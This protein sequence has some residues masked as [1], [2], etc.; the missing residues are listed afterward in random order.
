MQGV[1]RPPPSR[2]HCDAHAHAAPAREPQPHGVEM[3]PAQ[4]AAVSLL[5]SVGRWPPPAGEPRG[6]SPVSEPELETPRQRQLPAGQDCSSPSGL[7]SGAPFAGAGTGGER[8]RPVV[9]RPLSSGAP[10]G[11]GAAGAEPPR[12]AQVAQQPSAD[13]AQGLS[14][15]RMQEPRGAAAASP[16]RGAHATQ[17]HGADRARRPSADGVQEPRG[18]VAASPPR[19]SETA[20]QSQAS[21]GAGAAQP[22][23]AGPAPQRVDG[24]ARRGMDAEGRTQGS[25]TSPQPPITRAGSRQCLLSA[26]RAPLRVPS[27]FPGQGRVPPDR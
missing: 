26:G 5:R 13:G 18:A 8:S 21:Q 22:R 10:L 2:W 12:S 6:R 25:P 3:T 1:D 24:S 20:R 14:A 27:L 15:D 11:D 7:P 9:T 17:A 16:P 4:S 19:S 23:R